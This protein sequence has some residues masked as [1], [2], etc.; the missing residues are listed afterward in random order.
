MAE[1]VEKRD[2]DNGSC[3]IHQK[4]GEKYK[5]TCSE[6]VA[7]IVKLA[8]KSCKLSHLEIVVLNAMVFGKECTKIL[9]CQ[10]AA[11]IVELAE[12]NR[13]PKQL[14]QAAL[15]ILKIVGKKS[16]KDL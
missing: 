7:P 10:V 14:F 4:T 16:K 9:Y 15:S 6:A 13:S 11:Q 5:K 2:L 1:V 12:K 3:W 8:E